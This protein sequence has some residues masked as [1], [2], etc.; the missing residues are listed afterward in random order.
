MT[1]KRA[2][3]RGSVCLPSLALPPPKGASL[4]AAPSDAFSRV[5]RTLF[6]TH[7]AAG[8]GVLSRE[9]L[10]ALCAQL[11]KELSED[12]LDSA[13]RALD[14]DRSGGVSAKEFDVWFGLGLSL[15]SLAK[16]GVAL[17]TPPTMAAASAEASLC[18]PGRV[19][20]PSAFLGE[21]SM[22]PEEDEGD[23]RGDGGTRGRTRGRGRA[24]HV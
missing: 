22:V 20:W 23:G 2:Q 24:I 1:R 6:A 21:A 16:L 11:G 4:G 13:L 15:A 10:R 18:E 8:D 14:T 5:A 19:A 12:Q 7:D 3:T 9:E 17:V